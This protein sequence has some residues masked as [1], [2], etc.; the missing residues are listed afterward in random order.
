MSNDSKFPE[1]GSVTGS[2]TSGPRRKPIALGRGLPALLG[3]TLPSEV[4][5]KSPSNSQRAR[6]FNR[7]FCGRLRAARLATGLDENVVASRLSLTTEKYQ[8]FESSVL[9]PHF[10]IADLCNVL[11]VSADVLF[12]AQRR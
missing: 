6:A 11:Q 5:P 2:G 3:T 10:L 4:H 8:S 7:G 9:P 1:L 12:G